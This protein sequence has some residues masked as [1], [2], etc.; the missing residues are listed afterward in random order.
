[1]VRKTCCMRWGADPSIKFARFGL[2]AWFLW[3]THCTRHPGFVD[4]PLFDVFDFKPWYY[5]EG[6][7]PFCEDGGMEECEDICLKTKC[8]LVSV[9]RE[10]G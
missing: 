4:L 8:R 7:A 1:M 3:W 10:D 2:H 5:L 9:G 6:D